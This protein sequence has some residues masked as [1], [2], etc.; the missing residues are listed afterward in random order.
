MLMADFLEQLIS[1]GDDPRGRHNPNQDLVNKLEKE[2]LTGSVHMEKSEVEY[3]R[4]FYTPQGWK[5]EES[6]R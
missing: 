6:F 1:F 4:S 3:P 5:K 2:V